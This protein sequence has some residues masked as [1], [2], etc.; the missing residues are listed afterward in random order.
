MIEADGDNPR[1]PH[2]AAHAPSFAPDSL[3]A[4]L[5]ATG[6]VAYEIDLAR[7][8]I[9]FGG[10]AAGLLGPGHDR[11]TT[12]E[13]FRAA[14][15]A[16][17]QHK[18]DKALA[19]HMKTGE[20]YDCEY[21]LNG[22]GDGAIWVH[23]RARAIA[24]TTGA[25]RR[26]IGILRDISRRKANEARIEYLA[27]HDELTGHYNRARLREAVEH[28]LACSA[29]YRVPGAYLAVGI[30]RLSAI[31]DSFGIDVADAVIVEIGQRLTRSLRASD[32][33]GR[34]GGDRFG[35]VLDHCS[36]TDLPAVC[37][38][39]LHVMRERPVE[40]E[41][42]PISVSVSIGALGFLGLGPTAS[43]AM[44]RAEQALRQ[45]KQDG[46]N[47]WEL[48]A[49]APERGSTTGKLM[50]IAG[51]VQEALRKDRL[52]FAFQPVVHAIDRGV[53]HY[54]CLLRL[55]REDGTLM[56][57]GDFVPV[58]EQSGMMRA[59]ERRVLELAEQE[60][61]AN[62]SVKL[63]INISG[64]TASDRGWQRSLSMLMRA[65]AGYAQRLI[66]EITETVA[67]Q[68][69]DETARFVRAV[70]ELGCRV[71][72]D[73][74]GAGY[75]SFRNLKALAVDCVK[76]DGSFVKGLADNVDNQLFIRTL[77]GLAD[78]FG[79]STVAE[80]VETAAEASHLARR[81]VRYLQGFYFGRPSLERPWLAAA[82]P[83]RK[84][85]IPE[86]ALI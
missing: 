9:V 81:G 65:H 64:N 12:L 85:L 72:L 22:P 62:P 53:D 25:P 35:V 74:F 39:I 33:I 1:S 84:V 6:D 28:A 59:I 71:A 43:E 2:E 45:A 66:V 13:R 48:F 68:D 75:T 63:A 24:S 80:C 29:R 7:G 49:G 20:A 76:I 36:T 50:S 55:K 3:R 17:D 83:E 47:R 19:Q 37:E 15:V 77:L 30:D 58:I 40:T 10:P 57:A 73:D 32:V 42:G 8:T 11:I 69:I 18:R 4:A 14:I 70:R 61:R 60:L 78:G 31:N 26:L 79:L 82:P 41:T 44:N 46:R 27:N 56:A 52:M 51:A 38:K 54:E 5:E 23:D 67:L 34:L 86:S 21:R 16:L